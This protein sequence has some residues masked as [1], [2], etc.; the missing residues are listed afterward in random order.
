MTPLSRCVLVQG[1]RYVKPFKHRAVLVKR[2][3]AVIN[4]PVRKY[5][6]KSS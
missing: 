2:Y 6:E 5:A 3:S 1:C 4:Y